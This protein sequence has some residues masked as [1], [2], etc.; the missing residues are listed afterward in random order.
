MITRTSILALVILGAASLQP[1][2]AEADATEQYNNL[3]NPARSQRPS[4]RQQEQQRIQIER[5]RARETR[6]QRALRRELERRQEEMLR[7]QRRQNRG[8]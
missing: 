7:A 5:E 4:W 6:D 2:F 3:N 8:Y 1:A